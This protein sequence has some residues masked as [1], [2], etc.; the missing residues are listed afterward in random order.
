ML[1]DFVTIGGH[2]GVHQ[3]TRI[4]TLS[5]VGGCAK[6]ASDVP[7]YMLADGV[8][9]TVRGLN[10]IGLRRAGMAPAERRALRDAHRILY[11]SGR[12]PGPALEALRAA[13][14]AS[15]AVE[16]LIAFVAASKRGICA[17]PHG[18]SGAGSVP[19]DDAES[20]PVG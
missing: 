15:A 11:R 19:V 6:L 10:S 17:P 3:F 12:A 1:E 7:P 18:W 5:Y 2:T 8:P 13:A 4:G 20:E 14:P 9:A 16:R